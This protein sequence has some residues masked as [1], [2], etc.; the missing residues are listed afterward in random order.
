MKK[1]KVS[2]LGIITLFLGL[3][4]VSCSDDDDNG[5]G[6]IDTGV[7]KIVVEQSG[8][9]G[10][11]DLGLV[12]GAVNTNGPAKLYDENSKYFGD[13]YSVTEMEEIKVSCQTGKNAFFMTCAGSVTSTSD[14]P[15]RKLK[16]IITAYI[17]DKKVNQLVKEYETKQ[18]ILI[19]NFSISTTTVE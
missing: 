13:S 3:I 18:G 8:D 2:L 16:V 7:H 15:G 6:G 14:T 4:L 9:I 10:E 19:E 5:G 12:F 17:D 11:F 1:S